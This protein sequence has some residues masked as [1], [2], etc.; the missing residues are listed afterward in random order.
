MDDMSSEISE[1]SVPFL[2]ASSD[3]VVAGLVQVL[4]LRVHLRDFVNLRVTSV[5]KHC[6]PC[7]FVCLV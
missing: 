5:G 4:N 3:N 1:P 2:D 7:R 6:S